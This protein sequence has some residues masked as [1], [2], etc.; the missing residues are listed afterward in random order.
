M[1][2]KTPGWNAKRELAKINYRIH[3]DAIK[4]NLIPP[5]LTPQQTSIVYAS[6]SDVL[7]MALFGMTVKEWWEKNPDKKGNIRDYASINELICI[8]NMENINVKNF[9]LSEFEFVK[10]Y[11]TP[12]T[13]WE[14]N[15]NGKRRNIFEACRFC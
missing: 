5:E 10:L 6:E 11:F 2:D 12:V 1:I 14:E 9:V 4:V 8:S 15:V 7:N 3:T 13:L